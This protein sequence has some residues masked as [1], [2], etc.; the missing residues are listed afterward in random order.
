MRLGCL[1]QDFKAKPAACAMYMAIKLW[2]RVLK[3]ALLG[4]FYGMHI[5]VCMMLH[6]QCMG[7]VRQVLPPATCSASAD[8]YGCSAVQC[9]AVQCSAVQCSAVQCSAVQCSA[10]QWQS[11]GHRAQGTGHRAT[12]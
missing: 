6:C 11:T 4:V 7:M 2:Q 1:F 12:Q 5:Y 8:T 9:S 10:V 3:G